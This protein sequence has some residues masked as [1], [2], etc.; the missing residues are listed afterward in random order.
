MPETPSATDDAAGRLEGNTATLPRENVAAHTLK[1]TLLREACQRLR[2][3]QSG[4]G[5][6]I[7]DI[8]CGS[9]YAV[10]RFLGGPHDAVLGIDMYAPNVAYAQE[11]YTRPGL[12]FEY[13]S[14]ESLVGEAAAYDVI[15]LADVLE[16]LID[17]AGVL[18]TCASLLVPGGLLLLTVPNGFGPF[19]IESALARI[20]VLGPLSLTA[21]AYLVAVLN[22]W[23]PL[24][25]RWSEALAEQPA[26]LPYNADS[27]HVQFFSRA[28][29]QGLL[30]AA[31]FVPTRA[32]NLCFVAGP[33]TNFLFGSSERFCQW[34]ARIAARM[35]AA[36]TSAW[37]FECVRGMPPA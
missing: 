33:F 35:P 20:P 11:H 34:N 9:G 14:A 18:G 30:G 36:L 1:V 15:V 26:D 17:P 21:T 19:E 5:L 4:R 12:R 10:T 31:G 13:R 28:G 8:G 7:L 29:L 16:H 23:G 25:G 32:T 37:F 6:R 3:E 22:K 27:G 24:R 2:R